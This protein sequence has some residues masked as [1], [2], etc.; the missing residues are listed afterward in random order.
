MAFFNK[1]DD[2]EF[3][4]Y[5]LETRKLH[6]ILNVHDCVEYSSG[7][8]WSVRFEKHGSTTKNYATFTQNQYAYLSGDRCVLS[9]FVCDRGN[10]K[11]IIDYSMIRIINNTTGVELSRSQYRKILS[12]NFDFS[13]DVIAK[14]FPNGGDITLHSQN[15]HLILNECLKNIN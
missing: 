13:D 7:M 15:I 11:I 10:Y 5:V 9:L 8:Y 2:I 3:I 6:E 4:N 1:H 14:L 12:D